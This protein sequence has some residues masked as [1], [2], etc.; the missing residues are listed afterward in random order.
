MLLWCSWKQM[1]QF[2]LLLLNILKVE[3]C[4]LRRVLPYQAQKIFTCQLGICSSLKGC[5]NLKW[6]SLTNNSMWCLYQEFLTVVTLKTKQC[7]AL[8]PSLNIYRYDHVSRKRQCHQS[9]K[10]KTVMWMPVLEV[11]FSMSGFNMKSA[12][13]MTFFQFD[14]TLPCLT[15]HKGSLN[16]NHRCECRFHFKS[17]NEVAGIDL[18]SKFALVVAGFFFPKQKV[19]TWERIS[20]A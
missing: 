7:P 12:I 19:T 18:F 20:L 6:M 14:G 8:T 17:A 11:G 5:L 16:Q 4:H 2:S 15:R 3:A 13:A 9:F 10:D 1:M